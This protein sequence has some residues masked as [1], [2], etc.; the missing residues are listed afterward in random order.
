[1]LLFFLFFFQELSRVCV[2]AN[3]VTTIYVYSVALALLLLC[4]CCFFLSAY[5]GGFLLP[6]D[7][8]VFD[9][10]LLIF[11]SCVFL[12]VCRRG[13]DCFERKAYGGQALSVRRDDQG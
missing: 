13:A 5:V 8:L 11:L 2:L 7:L 10:S 9:R 3:A 12:S 1:M 6:P 4:F